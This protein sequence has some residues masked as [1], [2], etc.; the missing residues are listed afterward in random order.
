MRYLQRKSFP[1]NVL[2]YIISEPSSII[3]NGTENHTLHT[4]NII[5]KQMPAHY[6][7]IHL[8]HNPAMVFRAITELHTTMNAELQDNRVSA[9]L[10]TN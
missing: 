5:N 2:K 10:I 9:L 7:Y 6:I 8:F 4:L 3:S 1:F